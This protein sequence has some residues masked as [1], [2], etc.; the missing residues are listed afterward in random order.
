MIQSYWKRTCQCRC[1]SES[2]GTDRCSTCKPGS[3]SPTTG[4]QPRLLPRYRISCCRD[5]CS[6]DLRSRQMMSQHFLVRSTVRRHRPRSPCALR[7]SP[8][9]RRTRGTRSVRSRA[10][11]GQWHTWCNLGCVWCTGLIQSHRKRKRTCQCTWTSESCST[12]KPGSSSPTTGTQPRP[13]PCC[14]RLRRRDDSG[15]S[16]LPARQ[17]PGCTVRRHRPRNPCAPRCFSCQRGT[18]RTSSR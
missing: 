5:H 13:P 9:P 17:R 2:G 1:T 14:R 6:S 8:A 4:T 18:L 12:Y 11:S 7:C 16:G 3:S 15:S 10:G